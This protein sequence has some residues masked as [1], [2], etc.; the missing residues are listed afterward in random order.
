MTH[1][2]ERSA[3]VMHTAE[4]MFALVNDV[5]RYHE[6]LPWCGGSRVISHESN[7]MVASV[8]IAFKGVRKTFTTRNTQNPSDR[9]D[10]E[11]VDGPFSELVGAWTFKSISEEASRISLSLEFGFSSRV[12]EGLVGPVFR[13]IADSMVD[14]FCQRADQIY[15]GKE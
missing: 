1:K 3:L 13:L 9:L 6:F 14:S 8:D 11:L 10:M 2:V 12:V 15:S 7:I 4:Q 5:D